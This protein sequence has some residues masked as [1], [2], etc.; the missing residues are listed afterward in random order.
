MSAHRAT[1][2]N[3]I[4][5]T[6]ESE[7]FSP[8]CRSTMDDKTVWRSGSRCGK[9]SSRNRRQSV[10]K[11]V[12]DG[13]QDAV[14]ETLAHITQ[15]GHNPVDADRKQPLIAHPRLSDFV[16]SVKLQLQNLE[17]RV[18]LS[19]GVPAME[20]HNLPVYAHEARPI[21][22]AKV[23]EDEPL[24]HGRQTEDHSELGHV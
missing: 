12:V 21:F 4:E 1:I 3:G 9:S 6:S 20:A 22:E 17:F 11:F 13:R 14:C 10:D 5:M 19:E 16:S 7:L 15:V 23:A 18:D 2:G 24:L 8:D